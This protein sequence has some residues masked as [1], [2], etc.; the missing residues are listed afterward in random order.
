MSDILVSLLLFA[1]F[2]AAW[3]V[4]YRL[5]GLDWLIDAR[6]ATARRELAK[7]SH[8]FDGEVR[9][10]ASAPA[11]APARRVARRATPAAGTGAYAPA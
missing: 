8:A 5:G 6:M 4:L 2:G 10:V 1:G 9:P 11:P 3:S 7:S